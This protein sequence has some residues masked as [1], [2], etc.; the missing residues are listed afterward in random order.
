MQWKSMLWWMGAVLL[1]ACLLSSNRAR[2][3]DLE[4]LGMPSDENRMVISVEK[5][6]AFSK[7]V[8]SI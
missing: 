6:T 4:F 5:E 8:L 2:S 1:L 3:Q 7:T